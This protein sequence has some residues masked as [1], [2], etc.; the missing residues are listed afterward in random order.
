M[1]TKLRFRFAP[2]LAA[3]ALVCFAG[4]STGDDAGSQELEDTEWIGSNSFEVN[5]RIKAKLVHTATG[6]YGDLAT[7]VELQSE[8]VTNHITYAKNALEQSK[9]YLNM[10]PDEIL[11][12][13]I[14]VDGTDVTISY[15]ASIDMVHPAVNGKLP[16]SIDDLPRTQV[17]L[18]L[19]LDPVNVYGRAGKKCASDYGSYTLSEE[20]YFYYFDPD[21]SGCE[22]PMIDG[23]IEVVSVYPNPEVYPEYD[24]LLN[25]M[26]SGNTGF[27]AAI[28]PNSG[29]S[30]P[31]SRYK[32]HRRELN[33]VTGLEPTSEAGFERYA[34]SKDGATIIVDLFD[35]TV[36]YFTSDFHKALSAYQLVFYNGHSNYGHKP[37]LDKPEAYSDEY[38]IIGMHSCKSYSYYANQVATGKATAADPTGWANADMIATGRSSYPNDSPFVLAALL[39]GLMNGLGAVVEGEPERAPSWQSIGER[40]RA[41]A[42]SIL[43][44]VAGARNNAWKPASD[45]PSGDACAH[46]LCDTGPALDPSCDP[47]SSKIASAD[48]YCR[49]N[50]WDEICVELVTSEC[51]ISCQ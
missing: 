33:D 45:A 30:D 46:A 43:Y 40:M 2:L 10:M 13:D 22:V 29:D 39:D 35:P 34:W 6:G 31:M 28:L 12:M 3:S 49:D 25:D 44:G 26:G 51:A 32:A 1:V 18:T 5:A 20:K 15:E 4:C 37:Y 7:N 8:L 47:C 48:A 42:P 41:V 17:D 36:G 24:R 19:P 21:K 23:S 38:Q 11:S 16:E 14:S 50:F 27:R 9:Y